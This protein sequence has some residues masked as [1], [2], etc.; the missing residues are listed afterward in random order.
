[1]EEQLG[2]NPAYS[3]TDSKNYRLDKYRDA[4]YWILYFKK[5]V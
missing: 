4:F 1:M 5:F 2:K 3:S